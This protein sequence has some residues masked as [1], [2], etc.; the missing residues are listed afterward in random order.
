MTTKKSYKF[1]GREQGQRYIGE[2]L[3]DAC[4]GVHLVELTTWDDAGASGLVL[5][6]P[7]GVG[8]DESL[9]RTVWHRINDAAEFRSDG[10][11]RVLNATADETNRIINAEVRLDAAFDSAREGIDPS[12]LGRVE[13]CAKAFYDARRDVQ[14]R[15]QLECAL[16][17][18][19]GDREE[20]V[21]I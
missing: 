8:I 1:V 18:F 4:R 21:P 7:E 19:R 5:A 9:W 3:S 10:P 11:H 15:Q 12:A 14:I 20:V 17:T 2:T 6:R 13:V 16:A